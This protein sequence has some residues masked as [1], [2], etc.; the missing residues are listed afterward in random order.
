M[1]VKRLLK[2]EVSIQKLLLENWKYIL[3]IIFSSEILNLFINKIDFINPIYSNSDLNKYFE[4]AKVSPEITSEVIK[5]FV[6]RI[7]IPW[8]SELYHFRF[9]QIFIS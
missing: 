1:L 6:Y 4:M 2:K 3:I 5:P 7:V 8:V 9:L